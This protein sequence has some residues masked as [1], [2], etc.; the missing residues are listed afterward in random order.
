[1][2]KRLLI[3]IAVAGI[4]I[5][6]AIQAVPYGR[7]HTNP[8]VRGEPA[9][10]S[11]RTRALAAR[12]CFDCHSNETEWPWYANVAPISWLLQ[13]DVAE[14]RRAVNYSEWDR[15][16]KEGTES[17]KTVQK[18]EMPPWYYTLIQAKA[19]L[20]SAEREALIG[21]LTATLGRGE[22]AEGRER[23][24]RKSRD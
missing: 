12:A 17:A 24:R 22:G 18:G 20:T 4:V 11:S 3:G 21:G 13:W 19:R 23:E 9:W 1:M 8:P 16:Q 6:V 10:D 2:L 7:S 14:G 5:L 15:P